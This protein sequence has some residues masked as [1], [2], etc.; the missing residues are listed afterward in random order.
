M[1]DLNKTQIVLLTLLV[2]FVTSIATGITTVT[3]MD[4]APPAVIQTLNRVVEKTIE[5]IIQPASVITNEVKVFIKEEDLVASVF[6]KNSQSVVRIA[7]LLSDGKTKSIGLGFI[8]SEEGLIVTDKNLLSYDGEY[9]IKLADGVIWSIDIAT[10]TDLGLAL[11]LVKEK[12]IDEVTE[13]ESGN[14]LDS[15]KET[16]GIIETEDIFFA[17]VTIGYKNRVRTGQTVITIGGSRG[18]EVSV[19]IITKLDYREAEEGKEQS[20][21]IETIYTNILLSQV[22]SGGPILNTDG[23]TIG[24]NIVNEDG[25]YVVTASHI[26]ELMSS[27]TQAK[28]TID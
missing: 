25:R 24:L 20:N 9:F 16:V 8:I 22:S 3:L 5:T 27:L 21:I 12:I 4:Q 23:E 10:T 13:E 28:D 17:P 2:S 18:D 7:E 14:L 15:L 1:E 19:G 26:I 6:E 11:L